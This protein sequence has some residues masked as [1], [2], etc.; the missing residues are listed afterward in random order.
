MKSG[1]WVAGRSKESEDK[2]N[3]HGINLEVTDS[4]VIEL[5][6]FVVSSDML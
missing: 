5:N 4:H 1:T 3:K 6:L 2:T